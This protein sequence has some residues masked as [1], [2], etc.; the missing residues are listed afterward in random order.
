MAAFGFESDIA[1]AD[2]LT[3]LGAS[4]LVGTISAGFLTRSQCRKRPSP[5]KERSPEKNFVAN[6]SNSPEINALIND[7]INTANSLSPACGAQC[8]DIVSGAICKYFESYNSFWDS[9]K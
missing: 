1:F 2:G 3:L 9:G 6:D 7:V 5:L 4:T 8:K